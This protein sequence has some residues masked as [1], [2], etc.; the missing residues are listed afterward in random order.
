MSEMFYSLQHSLYGCTSP[1]CRFIYTKD[2]IETGEFSSYLKDHTYG[3]TTAILYPVNVKKWKLED[4]INLE[5]FSGWTPKYDL[6]DNGFEHVGE[7]DL[8]ELFDSFKYKKNSDGT[9]SKPWH[10]HKE[11]NLGDKKDEIEKILENLDY[12]DRDL[13]IY[14]TTR[15]GLVN[16]DAI[17]IFSIG[18]YHSKKEKIRQELTQHWLKRQK[19]EEEETK[20]RLA[21]NEARGIE[22]PDWETAK[23]RF[24]EFRK[25]NN[26]KNFLF[27]T[28][29]NT[30]Y[31]MES[32]E[33][34]KRLYQ[35]I[36]K[37]GKRIS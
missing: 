6:K 3:D 34:R 15:G 12:K 30:G 16:W 26:S 17:E 35:D 4:I 36:T 25:E 8:Y 27:D 24:E 1:Q 10:P 13:V 31:D 14:R 7:I 5:D 33:D 37:R 19:D 22:I 21:E 11:H 20:K 28:T 2:E 18:A 23:K 9:R 32:T 29:S